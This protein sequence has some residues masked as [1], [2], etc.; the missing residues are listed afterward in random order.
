MVP[1]KCSYWAFTWSP[2]RPLSGEQGA[3]DLDGGP[4]TGAQSDA[5]RASSD[6]SKMLFLARGLRSQDRGTCSSPGARRR[7]AG[8][9]EGV[10][11]KSPYASLPQEHRRRSQHVNPAVR[12]GRSRCSGGHATSRPLRAVAGRT[13]KIKERLLLCD[14]RRRCRM[15]DLKGDAVHG[16]DPEHARSSR[17][18]PGSSPGGVPHRVQAS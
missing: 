8:P 3:P 17:Q 10:S 13:R 7:P 6:Q 2:G 1:R 9:E 18:E 12:K 15:C 16:E 4:G 14:H 5:A 11:D